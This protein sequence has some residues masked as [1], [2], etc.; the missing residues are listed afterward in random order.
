MDLQVHT[1]IIQV[2]IGQAN[3][4]QVSLQQESGLALAEELTTDLH[5]V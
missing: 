2:S 5:T 4:K 1:R 3:L